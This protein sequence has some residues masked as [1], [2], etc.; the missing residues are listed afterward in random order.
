VLKK[1]SVEIAAHFKST[2]YPVLPAKGAIIAYMSTQSEVQTGQII[3]F[4]HLNKRDTYAPCVIDSQIFPA[5]ITNSCKMAKRSFNI[6][7]PVS[8]RK[9]P[10]LRQVVAVIVPGIAFD[11]KGNRLGFGGGYYDKFLKKLPKNSLKIALAFSSQI[12]KSVPSEKHD[13]KMDYVITEKG[14]FEL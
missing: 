3:S 13:I 5:R 10:S 11:K 12:V 2:L 8:G 14:V 7:E 4:L 1:H 9:L 6:Y